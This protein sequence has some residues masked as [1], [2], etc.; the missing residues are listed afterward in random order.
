L[1]F[2]SQRAQCS[3]SLA[4]P[5]MPHSRAA[6]A[7]QARHAPDLGG[8]PCE[9]TRCAEACATVFDHFQPLNSAGLR[10]AHHFHSRM[11][12]TC[13]RPMRLDTN[14]PAIVLALYTTP[15][16]LRRPARPLA[17]LHTPQI[18]STLDTF[19]SNQGRFRVSSRTKVTHEQWATC[20]LGSSAPH[21]RLACRG[22][23]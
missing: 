9:V 4:L 5:S 1:R 6:L 10:V 14:M 3:S 11:R 20:T 2:R 18:L 22:D 8:H 21:P 15:H 17:S 13:V 23:T 7:T 16:A 19:P 12:H